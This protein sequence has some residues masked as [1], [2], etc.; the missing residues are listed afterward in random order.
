MCAKISESCLAQQALAGLL[1]GTS[2]ITL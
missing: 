1:F 2:C